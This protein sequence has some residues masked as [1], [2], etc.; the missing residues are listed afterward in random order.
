MYASSMEPIPRFLFLPMV[1]VQEGKADR[2]NEEIEN[3][4]KSLCLGKN[5]ESARK[6]VRS[7]RLCLD[8]HVWKTFGCRI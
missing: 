2:K 1:K 5:H 4:K 6:G 8:N 3:F 7:V